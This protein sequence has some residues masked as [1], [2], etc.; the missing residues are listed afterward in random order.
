MTQ[1]ED[2][3]LRIAEDALERANTLKL[4]AQDL[5][6]HVG[7]KLFGRRLANFKRFL[8]RLRDYARE[9]DR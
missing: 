5:R 8:D 3:E 7:D 2:V 1:K 4:L 9:D 6:D